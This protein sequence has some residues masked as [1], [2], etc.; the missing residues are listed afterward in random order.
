[1]KRYF[2]K[3]TGSTP[4]VIFNQQDMA[5]YI[6]GVSAPYDAL[7]FYGH[8][9]SL[10]EDMENIHSDVLTV[11]IGFKRIEDSKSYLYILVKKLISLSRNGRKIIIN[12]FY[13]KNNHDIL[14]TGRDISFHYGF[15][16]LFTEVF[17]IKYHF[18][19]AC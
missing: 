17:K 3:P 18:L 11:N 7:S 9:Y 14:L 5:L 8:V 1:M 15:P 10:I 4:S 13:E 2:L 12:W 6:N 19:E 16:F